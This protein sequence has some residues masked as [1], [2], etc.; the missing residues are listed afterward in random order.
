MYKIN[1]DKHD[2]DEVL[3]YNIGDIVVVKSEEKTHHQLEGLGLYEVKNIL[4]LDTQIG[5]GRHMILVFLDVLCF[6]FPKCY[7]E[8][9]FVRS[10]IAEYYC[11]ATKEE[12]DKQRSIE[13]SVVGRAFGGF[14]YVI[15]QQGGIVGMMNEYGYVRDVDDILAWEEVVNNT[16]MDISK[17]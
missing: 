11:K 3:G 14:W 12:Q 5:A 17:V 10:D 9:G 8:I 1:K 4:W 13:A 7:F 16:K 2:W 15:R 6:P